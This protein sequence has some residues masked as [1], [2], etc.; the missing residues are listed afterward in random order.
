MSLRDWCGGAGLL[1]S[2]NCYGEV[3]ELASRMVEDGSTRVVGF[4]TCLE[5]PS[6]VGVD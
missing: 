5:E 3:E 2:L 6:A 4:E 1:L